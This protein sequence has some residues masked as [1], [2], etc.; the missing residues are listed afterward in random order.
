VA[1]VDEAG[2]LVAVTRPVFEQREDHDLGTAFLRPFNRAAG[3][4]G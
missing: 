4:G 2:D 1:F 3:H